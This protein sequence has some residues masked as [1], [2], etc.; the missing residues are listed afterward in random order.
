MQLN[1]SFLL[2]IVFL[3]HVIGDGSRTRESM[4][5]RRQ[6]RVL[7]VADRNDTASSEMQVVKARNA[8]F[9]I[10]NAVIPIL[11]FA[12]AEGLEVVAWKPH[13]V[14]T[15][16]TLNQ[17]LKRGDC[18]GHFVVCG[19]FD[20]DGDDEFL[21][22]LMGSLDRD[23]NDDMIPPTGGLDANKGIVYYKAIDL[24]T[25]IFAKWKIAEESSA[26]IEVGNFNGANN[27]DVASIAYNVKQYYEEPNPT[28][29]I[30]M[31][32]I[33]ITKPDTQSKVI[34]TSLWDGGAIVYVSDPA[35]VHKA[36]SAPLI[37]VANFAIILYGSIKDGV[38]TR[39]PMGGPPFPY[40]TSTYSENTIIEADQVKGAIVL[41]FAPI[42]AEEGWEDLPPKEWQK[43]RMCL[44][45]Q[46]TLDLDIRG[47]DM[48]PLSFT[49][50]EDLWWGDKF[51][52]M[53]FYNLTSFHFRFPESK[54][55]IAHMQ[56]WILGNL[57][58]FSYIPISLP[59]TFP[60]IS[61][62]FLPSSI[63]LHKWLLDSIMA[64]LAV[65]WKNYRAGVS[66]PRHKWQAG[67]D[68]KNVDVWLALEFNPDLAL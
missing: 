63:K 27:L 54:A 19:D 53:E 5:R 34:V 57:Y 13:K 18:P 46:P 35:Q 10:N 21:I 62:F 49:K 8:A 17:A 24:Q 47:L 37:E 28:V 59:S 67:D 31:N 68:G 36:A 30:H 56:F 25:G 60:S 41:R 65:T 40:T 58:I 15:Y 29:D 32:R 42:L 7:R 9:S 38:G 4:T 52:G 22:S 48:F 55:H 45:E 33:D 66:Y 61:P 1:F 39:R 44:W 64:I 50:V 2:Q 11:G 16:G 26:S 14:D 23:K 6:R 51:K 43:Q 12:C 3:Y 20:G